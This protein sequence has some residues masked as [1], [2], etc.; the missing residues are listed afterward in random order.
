MSGFEIYLRNL[1]H[2]RLEGSTYFVTW[3][4][5]PGQ[6]DLHDVERD[7]ISASIKF[8]DGKRLT[9]D[10]YVVMH[11]HVHV[12]LSPKDK[13]K[14]EQLVYS[15][16]RFTATK[17]V[18]EFSRGGPV[19]QREY[20]DHIIRNQSDWEEKVNYVLTNPQRRWGDIQ[21]YKWVYLRDS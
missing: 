2:W 19:W 6:G 9:L 14:L 5:S 7:M 8:F 18:M 16:K 13:W 20:Y 10:A 15:L 21:N 12:V 1:P 4:L 17:M 3:R 11:D